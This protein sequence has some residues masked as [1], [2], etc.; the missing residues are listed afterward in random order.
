[1]NDR[2]TDHGPDWDTAQAGDKLLRTPVSGEDAAEMVR[3]TAR[4]H[5]H[6]ARRQLRRQ[7]DH[8]L[9]LGAPPQND[10]A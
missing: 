9:A 8:R 10:R 2:K 7:R 1:M 5:P 6:N 3:A 4:L